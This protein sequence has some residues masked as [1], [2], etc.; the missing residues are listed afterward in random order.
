[1]NFTLYRINRQLELLSTRTD[2]IR[3]RPCR[4]SLIRRMERL[5]IAHHLVLVKMKEALATE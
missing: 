5:N 3:A 2:R 1:M 4:D